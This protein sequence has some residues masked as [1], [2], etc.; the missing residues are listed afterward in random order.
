MLMMKKK[1][2]SYTGFANLAFIFF[3]QTVLYLVIVVV[4]SPAPYPVHRWWSRLLLI[5]GRLCC[6]I[7][8]VI[9]FFC[10]PIVHVIF[11]FLSLVLKV[12]HERLLDISVSLFRPF[13]Y[14][15]M[16]DHEFIGYLCLSIF[17]VILGIWA[18][19]NF[20]YVEA[21]C[22]LRL[23]NPSASVILEESKIITSI[24]Y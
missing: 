22:F 2:D 3:L 10:T 17:I 16:T 19:Q 7:V 8:H 11:F 5:H 20:C 12:D 18:F 9:F 24:M 13:P 1:K 6:C 21:L 4:F 23:S 14:N 15:V